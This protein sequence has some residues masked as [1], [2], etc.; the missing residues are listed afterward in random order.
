MPAIAKKGSATSGHGGF[1]PTVTVT[2]C[3]WFTVNGIEINTTGDV[4]APHD[5]PKT[6]PHSSVVIGGSYM[7]VGGKQVARV[8]DGIACGDTLVSGDGFFETD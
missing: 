7:T 2:G 3:G 5:K 6:P 4:I 1:H 8:G